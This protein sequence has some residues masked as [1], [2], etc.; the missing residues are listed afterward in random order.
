MIAFDAMTQEQKNPTAEKKG[1]SP[2]PLRQNQQD[3]SGENH[4][5]T[6]TVEELVPGGRV[7]VIILRH[8]TRQTRH[9]WNSAWGR[10]LRKYTL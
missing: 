8:V 10:C 5:N 2:N 9:N 6:D 1:R 3:D 7:F 4:R